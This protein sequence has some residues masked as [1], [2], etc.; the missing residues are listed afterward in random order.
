MFG[1]KRQAPDAPEAIEAPRGFDEAPPLSTAERRAAIAGLVFLVVIAVTWTFGGMDLLS[2]AWTTTILATIDAVQRFGAYLVMLGA[3]YL[4][5]GAVELPAI[6]VP[7]SSG[8][9]R[10]PTIKRTWYKP[11]TFKATGDCYE[12]QEGKATAT[13]N[14]AYIAKRG[15]AGGYIITREV[16]RKQSGGTVVYETIDIEAT[17]S[18]AN[19]E[20]AKLALREA[21]TLRVQFQRERTG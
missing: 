12:W 4:L 15:K 2:L 13:I 9:G 7:L 21:A 11:G 6:V 5:R 3:G 18:K 19:D 8:P 20:R 1:R 16:E 17:R 10:Q 14:R